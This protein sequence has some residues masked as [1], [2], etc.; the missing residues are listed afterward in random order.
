MNTVMN[1]PFPQYVL[2]FLTDC[3]WFSSIQLYKTRERRILN[4]RRGQQ[5]LFESISAECELR[6][7]LLVADLSA[8]HSLRGVVAA[9]L[10]A[11]DN[12]KNIETSDRYIATGRHGPATQG[13]HLSAEPI[14]F[15]PARGRPDALHFQFS[16]AK[17]NKLRGP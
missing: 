13:S 2:K 14:S 15:C 11:A 1:L 8:W 5:Q 9:A 10:C 6:F 7:T 4:N 17:A 12:G 3:N 16:P